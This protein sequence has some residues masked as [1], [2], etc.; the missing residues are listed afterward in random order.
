MCWRRQDDGKGGRV[1]RAHA[2]VC[3]R[4]RRWPCLTCATGWKLSGR[5]WAVGLIDWSRWPQWWAVDGIGG[6]AAPWSIQSA[7]GATEQDK[8]VWR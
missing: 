8:G 4:A 3:V 1:F 7:D 6:A 2:R 5:G